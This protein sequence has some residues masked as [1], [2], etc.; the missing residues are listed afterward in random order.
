MFTFESTFKNQNQYSFGIEVL[1]PANLAEGAINL[2]HHGNRANE[3]AACIQ[4]LS[5]ELPD[6]DTVI[7]YSK[8]DAD[9]LLTAAILITRKSNSSQF[10]RIASI[11]Q[12]FDR[13]DRNGPSAKK[14]V[15]PSMGEMWDTISYIGRQRMPF[16]DM[17]SI[18]LSI[19]DGDEQ[20]TAEFTKRARLELEEARLRTSV[21][22]IGEDFALVISS[23]QLGTEL[24]YETGADLLVLY[25]PDMQ[26]PEGT[27]KKG[28]ICHQPWYT[29]VNLSNVAKELNRLELA[30]GQDPDK[31]WGGR[32]TI[33]GSP[34]QVDTKISPD[35]MIEVVLKHKS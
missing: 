26:G 23:V 12:G 16:E 27:W 25:N 19:L 15:S 31:T 4:A 29:G 3:P 17:L 35:E 20:K 28:T 13:I 2:D 34:F 22:K 14:T 9:T 1:S 24:G 18:T 11:A 5:I 10:N 30:L 6:D 7:A 8:A 32:G 21:Q 33:I